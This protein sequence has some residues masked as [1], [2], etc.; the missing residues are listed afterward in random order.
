MDT[1]DYSVDTTEDQRIEVWNIQFFIDLGF[2]GDAAT[3][4]VDWKVDPH[5][6]R[7]L[8][9]REGVRTKCTHELALE[10]LHPVLV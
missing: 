9:F 1:D 3:L 6:A 4:L 5:E 7:R 2:S 8:L 10:I